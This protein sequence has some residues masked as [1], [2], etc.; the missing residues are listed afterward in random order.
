MGNPVTALTESNPA[1]SVTLAFGED[2]TTGTTYQLTLT[3]DVANCRGEVLAAGSSV[4][5]A[6]PSPAGKFDVLITE[7]MADPEPAEGLPAFEY[8]EL[9]NRSGHTVSLEGWTLTLG[10]TE[11]PISGLSLASGEYVILAD[12]EASAGLSPFGRFYG[13]SSLS[14]TNAGLSVVL[15]SAQGEVISWVD[16]TD[17]WYGDSPKKN[18]GWSL[19]MADV[20]NPCT[21]EGNW[22]PSID[23]AGGTPGMENSVKTNNPD[24]LKPTLIRII[25]ADA[26]HITAVFSEPIDSAGLCRTE[27]YMISNGINNP[28]SAVPEDYH[29]N[30]V[31]LQLATPLTASTIYTL[32]ITADQLPDCA[33]NLLAA[34]DGISFGLPSV[35]GPSD[36]VMNE[37][38]TNPREG[39]SDYL[40][41]MNRSDKV[42]DLGS[43][44]LTYQSLTSASNPKTIFPGSFLLLPGG[45]YCLT[46]SPQAVLAQ[47]T[48][49]AP[50]NFV[51]VDD[52][53]DFTSD[54]GIISLSLKENDAIVIDRFK[55]AATMHYALLNDADGVA[56]EKIN[57]ARSASDA[58]NWHSASET[59]GY[60]TP[61]M[62]NSQFSEIPQP[63][64]NITVEPDVFSPDNDGYQDNLNIV[65][66][67][68]EPGFTANIGIYDA[69]GRKLRYLA[70]NMLLG[71]ENTLSWDGLT[72]DNTR[73]TIGI[74]I[75]LAEL[76]DLKG[77]TEVL[78][79][80][81]VVGGKL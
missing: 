62:Q 45:Y 54:S 5:F 40:E 76:F 69:K 10:S 20:A 37:L 50:A 56:L 21:M 17:Q 51:T 47:H 44:A 74:Y 71:T 28:L 75:I 59:S 9:F 8:I 60:G 81:A 73:A 31:M 63:K 34:C 65:I 35:P 13:L 46:R 38:L 53:S 49:T 72:D 24:T 68:E 6:M 80:T 14:L 7:I 3:Q 39:G 36:V 61:A 32:T 78:K 15:R 12:E 29:N 1:V 48:S 4:N 33:G 27:I 41:L 58:T 30:R 11:K 26:T 23:A 52:L 64:G 42:F 79:A 22:K 67:T 43:F 19:E 66:K 57:P 16:Y 25:I 55:Y 2:F 70:K 18:G 77:N